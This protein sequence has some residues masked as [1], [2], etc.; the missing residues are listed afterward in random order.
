MHEIFRGSLD[1]MQKRVEKL[2]DKERTFL[3][4][5]K[6]KRK[7]EQN[8]VFFPQVLASICFAGHGLMVTL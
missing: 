6:K 7:T 5:F 8:K 2:K 4:I 3:K 1:H